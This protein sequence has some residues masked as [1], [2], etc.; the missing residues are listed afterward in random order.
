MKSF[1]KP[2]FVCHPSPL[3]HSP[4]SWQAP[5]R[6]MIL[7]PTAAQAC[8]LI[9]ACRSPPPM[10]SASLLKGLRLKMEDKELFKV[11]GFG[12]GWRASWD[13]PPHIKESKPPSAHQSPFKHISPPGL[14]THDFLQFL[15]QSNS[16]SCFKAQEKWPNSESKVFFGSP[17]PCTSFL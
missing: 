4:G 2:G 17:A 7:S 9:L 8:Y 6:S 5:N 10:V 13:A 3:A 15:L 1:C 14:C 16:Y 11:C 12:V